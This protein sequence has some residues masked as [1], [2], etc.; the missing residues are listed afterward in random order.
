MK[1]AAA[2]AASVLA[3][4]LCIDTPPRV[5]AQDT[6]A[7]AAENLVDMKAIKPGQTYRWG[8]GNYL[9]NK[10]DCRFDIGGA[11]WGP[12]NFRAP[13]GRGEHRVDSRQNYTAD[14]VD[15]NIKLNLI[16]K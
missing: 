8:R 15:G 4:L 13:T 10:G 3:V 6:K 14:C 7:P 9:E 5:L 1:R 12:K 16:D 11:S 2:G